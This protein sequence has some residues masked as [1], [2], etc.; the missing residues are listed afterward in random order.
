MKHKHEAQPH[1]YARSVRC[2]LAYDLPSSTGHS[3]HGCSCAFDLCTSASF[4]MM[5]TVDDCAARSQ[6]CRSISAAWNRGGIRCGREAGVFPLGLPAHTDNVEY[7]CPYQVNLQ[8]PRLMLSRQSRSPVTSFR[9]AG[10]VNLPTGARASLPLFDCRKR[11]LHLLWSHDSSGQSRACGA[12][13]VACCPFR[14]KHPM[15]H[16]LST[17]QHVT[18]TIFII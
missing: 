4:A 5:I 7:L 11:M 13:T 17:T 15:S 6:H 10:L 8:T 3:T 14:T 12:R 1:S 2:G 18:S 16:E 9:C